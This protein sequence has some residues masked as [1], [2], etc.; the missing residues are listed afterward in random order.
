MLITIR[1]YHGLVKY[2]PIGADDLERI[3]DVPDGFTA[4]KVLIEL[5]AP[6]TKE[7]LIFVNNV[8]AKPDKV[9]HDGDLLIAMEIAGG[10]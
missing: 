8:K 5:G 2:L 7:S 9:L 1:L 6:N 3:L 4:E 10:G